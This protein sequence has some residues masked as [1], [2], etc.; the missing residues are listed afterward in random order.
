MVTTVAGPLEAAAQGVAVAG[1]EQNPGSF[2]QN[3]P[4]LWALTLPKDHS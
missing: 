4:A 2:T 3:V 1:A